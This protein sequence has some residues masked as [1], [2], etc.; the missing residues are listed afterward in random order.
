AAR[1]GIAAVAR[2][3]QQCA[4]LLRLVRAEL[5]RFEMPCEHATRKSAHAITSGLEILARAGARCRILRLQHQASHHAAGKR[6][7]RRAG[8]L[9]D[10]PRA[11]EL[12]GGMRSRPDAR[13]VVR[14]SV[15]RAETAG[16]PIVANRLRAPLRI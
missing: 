1:I 13:R 11:H 15:R 6:L 16:S 14:T 2:L 8:L 3:R 12:R 9:E 10:P 4:N 7:L 5:A